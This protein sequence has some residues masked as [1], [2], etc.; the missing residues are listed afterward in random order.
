MFEV[1]IFCILVWNVSLQS[2]ILVC[3]IN[4]K[5][6]SENQKGRDHLQMEA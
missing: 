6:W 4:T 1:F 5:Y 3:N 2:V